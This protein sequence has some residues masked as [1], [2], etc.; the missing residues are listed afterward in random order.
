MIISFIGGGNMASALIGGLLQMTDPPRIQVADTNPAVRERLEQLP[1]VVTFAAAEDAVQGASLVVLALKP[2]VLPGVMRTL[3]PR[4]SAGQCVVSVAAGIT[5]GSLQSWLAEGVAVVRTM[6]NTPALLGLG[7]TGLFAD[8]QCSPEQRALAEQVMG[9]VGETVWVETERQ[10]DAVTAISGSGP[11]YY[12]L[13]TEA[14]TNAGIQLGLPAA[15]SQRLATLT[16]FG[17][18][19]M[20][21]AGE[22][23]PATLR[24]KVTSP[25]GTTAAA[26]AAFEEGGLRDLV[27]R[28]AAAADRRSAELSAAGGD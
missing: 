23:D 1:G 3:G 14:L 28:A 10:I 16:A 22:D 17:A 8:P 26:I 4:V 20:L 12:Y 2:Q 25:G 24:H 13:F 18:G 15:T 21:N 19:S 27:Q 7:I 6:P 11:A 9:A 5:L